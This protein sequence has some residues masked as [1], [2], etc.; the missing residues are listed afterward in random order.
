MKR[1]LYIVACAMKGMLLASLSLIVR[2]W[3]VMALWAVA[4]IV[5]HSI[6]SPILF[7]AS[8]ATAIIIAVRSGNKARKRREDAE[9]KLRYQID[10]DNEEKARSQFR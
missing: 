8:T 1:T 9:Q 4:I 7:L 3:L 2:Y 6:I 10:R 5:H